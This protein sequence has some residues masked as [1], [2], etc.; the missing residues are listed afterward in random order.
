MDFYKC[1][2]NGCDTKGEP[3]PN[4]DPQR[5]YSKVIGNEIPGLYDGVAFWTCPVCG[6][7]WHRFA[8]DS[9]LQRRVADWWAEHYKDVRLYLNDGPTR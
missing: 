7:S 2:I 8:T 4:T 6:A 1:P 3:I 5:W 9:S